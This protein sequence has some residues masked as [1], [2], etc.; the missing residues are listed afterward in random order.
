MR[1]FF[2]AA[3]G[4]LPGLLLSAM[5]ASVA[6]VVST[7]V[8]TQVMGF[9]KSPVS[10]ILVAIVTGLIMRN[11]AIVGDGFYAGARF[12]ARRV[13]RCGI[14]LLGLSLSVLAVGRTGLVVVPLVALC[15]CTG[16]AVAT[17]LSR[18][19][20]VS[21]RL[22]TLI[23]VGTGICGASAIAATAP[24][25]GAKDEEA[26][27]AVAN[28]ALFGMLATLV[29]PFLTVAV[30]GAEA[31]TA[32]IFLGTSIHDTSQVTG[33]G[34]IHSDLTGDPTGLHVAVTTKLVRNLF[35]VV[36]IPLMSVLY[37][38]SEGG[39]TAVSG[40]YVMRYLPITIVAFVGMTVLRFAGDATMARGG[41]A[42][43]VFDD[44]GWVV[45]VSHSKLAAK[46]LLTVAMAGVGLGTD[47][48]ALTRLGVKPLYVG[49]S[50]A[51]TVGLVSYLAIMLFPVSVLSALE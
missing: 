34:M 36:V 38:R 4:I 22:G 6:G 47:L 33:A 29:Y 30:Y 26:S 49:M 8:G 37:R 5:L 45:V 41:R 21:S 46:Y 28:I 11:L 15:I 43:W 9:E 7:F 1:W 25:I 20:G 16:L 2:L 18:W 39:A 42:L 23:A 50:A 35:M 17:V 51:A 19:L 10:P 31:A 14:V 12:C 32:G 48:R 44:A 13:L 24:V 3:G 27:Y 40:G